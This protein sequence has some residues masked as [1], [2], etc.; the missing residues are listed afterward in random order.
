MSK[1]LESIG[2]SHHYEA[3]NED[4]YDDLALIVSMDESEVL[5]LI[6]E[7][8]VPAPDSRTLCGAIAELRR[9]GRCPSLP[10]SPSIQELVAS[11][12]EVTRSSSREARDLEIQAMQRRQDQKRRWADAELR[13]KRKQETEKAK[14][15]AELES[16]LRKVR[17]E[18]EPDPAEAPAKAPPAPAAQVDEPEE[19]PQDT[20]EEPVQSEADMDAVTAEDLRNDKS[21]SYA[22]RFS[23]DVKVPA[24][25]AAKNTAIAEAGKQ[26]KLQKAPPAGEEMTDP[27][28]LK[29]AGWNKPFD[30]LETGIDMMPIMPR[31][32][33]SADVQYNGKGKWIAVQLEVMDGTLSFAS[34]Q[35]KV[36]RTVHGCTVSAPKKARKGREYTFRL[37]TADSSKFV[38]SLESQQALDEW[39]CALVAYTGRNW[40]SSRKLDAVV[41]EKTSMGVHMPKGVQKSIRSALGRQEAQQRLVASLC[42]V[43][44]CDRA[45]IFLVDVKTQELVIHGSIAAAGIRIPRTAGIVGISATIGEHLLIN[46]PYSDPRFDQSVDQSIGYTT[47]SILSTPIRDDSGA[48]VGVL[49]AINKEGGGFDIEAGHLDTQMAKEFAMLA[50]TTLTYSMSLSSGGGEAFVQI[51]PDQEPEHEGAD[52]DQEVEECFMVACPDGMDAGQLLYVTS[53]LGREI[54]LYVPDG[55]GPGDLIQVGEGDPYAGMA[56]EEAV[57]LESDDEDVVV[58]HEESQQLFEQFEEKSAVFDQLAAE[59]ADNLKDASPQL[60]AELE[61]QVGSL[62]TSPTPMQ[63]V[64]GAV[65]AAESEARAESRRSFSEQPAP[66]STE[67]ALEAADRALEA[68]DDMPISDRYGMIAAPL[69][70]EADAGVTEEALAADAEADAAAMIAAAQE[71]AK[72]EGAAKA[73]VIVQQAE[74]RAQ[75]VRSAVEGEFARLASEEQASAESRTAQQEEQARFAGLTQ[76]LAVVK[77]DRV[78]VYSAS[79][80]AWLRGVV[81]QIEDGEAE[82][83]Y[84]VDGADRL[85][86]VPLKDPLQIVQDKEPPAA[87]KLAVG[88]LVKVYSGS[89]GQWF[90]G[91]IEKVEAAEAEVRYEVDGADRLKWVTLDDREQLMPDNDTAAAAS[92]GLVVT[93]GDRVKVYSASS[94]QW[95]PGVVEQVEASEAEVRYEVEGSDRLKWVPMNDPG[96]LKV[97][98]DAPAG[99]AVVKGDR[100]KVYSASSQQWFS[101]SVEQVNASTGEAEVRY[102]VDG[103]DRLKWVALSDSEQVKMDED[104]TIQ[105]IAEDDEEEEEEGHGEEEEEEQEQLV[106]ANDSRVKVYS[107]SADAWLG[108]VVEEVSNG[109]AQVRYTVDGEDRVKWASLSD[110]DQMKMDEDSIDTPRTEEP[111][112]AEAEPSPAAPV[113]PSMLGS[114]DVQ[115]NGKGKWFAAQMKLEDGTLSFASAPDLQTHTRSC[116]VHGCTVSA[117]KKA[118]KG[119]EYTFRLDTADSSKF[120]VSLESQQALDEW[121][122]ALVA[123]TGRNWSSSR[124]L[125]AVVAEKTS[126]GVH[127]P[128]G[129]QKSIRS[130]L[131]RQE[132]QQRLVAS[133]CDVMHCDRASIFLVDVKTQ[134]LVI[135]GSIAAAGIRIPRTAGI[136]GIS[137]TIGEHLLINDPYSDPRF[138]QSVDQ[139]IGYTTT[140]ILSTP[141]RDD[142]GAI[143]GVLQAINKEGGGF[144][145]EAGHLDTQMA[146]EFAMLAGTTLTYSMSLSSGGG[147]AFVQIV[148]DQEPEHEGADDDQEV[149]ECFMVA[150]PDGM[151][152]GQLLYVTSPLGREIELYVPDGVGPGDLIQ[153]GEGDPYAGMAEEE[154]VLL[155]SDDEDV[156][157]LH[158]ESQ[159]LFEQFE[160]KS[161]VF[162]QLAAETADNLKDASPQLAAELEPQVGSLET[163]PTPMQRVLGAVKAAESE[164]RAESRRSF[165]EQPAPI[166]TEDALEA[167]DR[168]LEALDDMPISD[169]YGMI[170]APL[171]GEA[172]AGVTEEA[173][174]ADAEADAAAMIAAAQEEAKLEGAAK[175]EVIVQQAEDRAQNVRSAVEGEFARLASEEQASAESRTA[176]QEEQARFAGLTQQL[177]VVKGDRVKVYSASAEAW[178]RGVV[179]QIEDGEAE[180]RYEVDG[181]D[182]LKWVPL[183]DPLQIV[184]DKEPPAAK[185]LAVGNLVKVYSG[186]AGQ[187]FSGSIEKV[188]AAEAEVRYEVD[189]ADRLKWVTLD[190]RE[191][192]MPDN[193]TAAAASAGLVVTKGD[194]VKVYSASSDQWFPGVVEQVEASEAEVR[195]EV[196]GSDRLKWVPMND[197]G[198][199]KVNTD[200]P[201]G[202]AVVKGDRVKVYSASSQ[203]WFSGSVEQVNA[204]TGEAEVRYE[205]DGSDRLK[206]V[207]LSDAAQ[208]VTDDSEQ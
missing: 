160:E 178:L 121:W 68:L 47:T 66:I 132:A 12:G 206:R 64:L 6:D 34:A 67:D 183:K 128:K 152:A 187:W 145:I 191:Q 100:V 39:W 4:G 17:G 19:T 176:Q 37:D 38:V 74:D 93:K 127:M 24:I 186:S 129:V 3:L 49:Q 164:A 113:L 88:N 7:L 69:E 109:E 189:G 44:H 20:L 99:L 52:D 79:A 115:Y 95:F 86:W 168:A 94:D 147:E 41:A 198:Q 177:A 157:V 139:S 158:E 133:L 89:A 124:K 10:G 92:A 117:P 208:V 21:L 58:L 16:E 25:D 140:S 185:K 125:D 195:Y 59:T 141:I 167:A 156:V 26:T 65:K 101:G 184:Q 22:Q 179:E 182:R 76:Q 11:V 27:G 9:Q 35:G 181:A 5:D 199:L 171:E 194:R 204:S 29:A 170:A 143:V 188:E 114:A 166:S 173:L 136:V 90:S 18:P 57:L 81:E 201:A 112:A 14:R 163:S 75:N 98:T 96:Q 119:R 40:S 32:L 73:E 180:V 174:A 13:A 80:E 207:T 91:S 120:V 130:A 151:D 205:V 154:A 161:A 134:E 23:M 165:S 104:A 2:L 54:E 15:Q 190:D 78:K 193:D 200:A 116:S 175:A 82:V 146:K 135:H 111:V 61:P 203:Q 106:V 102:E 42:D 123:Y 155:E 72:L 60:A 55:V 122:C 196:E 107:A 110:S 87:K 28:K 103:S 137:A 97:N 63:R 159:Q 202:L 51:V 138:D 33:G 84:E 105:S 45:S 149:E 70:G 71:E 153:V 169:R 8:K 85:K 48:I 126:M 31:M 77:G 1:W 46:D 144:D 43:M 192:L 150:C 118:R 108:G 30:H 131:G 172:D 142:S 36:T 83:R 197:P 50:G 62:E 56:E 53:P 148:P 162:D